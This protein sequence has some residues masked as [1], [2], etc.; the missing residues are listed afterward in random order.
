MPLAQSAWPKF[1][2]DKRGTGRTA[3]KGYKPDFKW[4]PT[5]YPVYALL[6]SPIEGME[7]VIYC[8]DY[9]GYIYAINPDRTLKW[10]YLT[11]GPT[12]QCTPAQADDGTI[13]AVSW[14]GYLYALNPNGTLKWRYLVSSINYE[15]CYGINIDDEGTVYFGVYSEIAFYALNPN[16]TLKWV[17]TETHVF[18]VP[19]IGA[20]GTIYVGGLDYVFYAFN[21]DGTLKWSYT[22]DSRF[23]YS[24]PAVDVV[25]E[26]DTIQDV[27][28]VGNE[29]RYLYA[30]SQVGELK[31]R[32]YLDYLVFGSPA[33]G[34][35]GTVYI[36]N[37]VGTL[38]AVSPNG[39]VR[40]TFVP[41]T[42]PPKNYSTPSVDGQGVIYFGTF[43]RELYAL[44]TDGTKLWK[45]TLPPGAEIESNPALGYNAM[46]VTAEGVGVYAFTRTPIPKVF[47]RQKRFTPIILHPILSSTRDQQEV[48]P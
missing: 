7:G 40:W 23:L 32:L 14:D 20:K 1:K 37:H 45:I 24:S 33:L 31:W 17:R 41:D 36:A 8:S 29:D 30:F 25:V 38:Y 18:N 22:A 11:G 47:P 46:Y 6:N 19:A 2:C 34:H 42:I 39:L 35:D 16:G 4:S 28:Y 27:I 9:E 5:S 13:F 48:G 15:A 10:R 3:Y 43:E 44:K 21:P 12:T 26:D